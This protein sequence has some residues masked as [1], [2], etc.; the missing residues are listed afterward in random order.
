MIRRREFVALV[1]GAV[2]AWPIAARAQQPAMPVIGYLYT[3]SPEP[4]AHLIA[5]FRNGLSEIGYVEGQNVAIEFRW[6]RNDTDRLP[7]MAADLV[8]RRVAVIATPAS[9]VGALA[10]KAATTTIPVVFSM[11]GDPVQAGLVASFNSPGGNVTGV[12]SMNMELGSKRLGLLHELVPNA[13]R[14]AVLVVKGPITESLLQEVQAGASTIGRKIDVVY[15]STSRDI[16]TAFASIVQKRIDALVLTPGP[17]FNNN[18]VQL[19]TLAARHAV[20]TIYSSR[21]FAEAGGLMSYGPNIAEE[22]RQTGIYCGRVLK[23]EKPADLPV[24]R[25]TKFEL[26]INLQTARAFGIAVPPTLLAR[27]DEVIE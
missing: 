24:M 12:S 18:R 7:E 3:G 25:A 27:A 9:T 15:A 4:S 17:L 16:D 26:V 2:A 11:G 13:E 10:A 23:G 5:A 19:A 14:F 1:G 8:R 21:E 20:P 22:F 6:A